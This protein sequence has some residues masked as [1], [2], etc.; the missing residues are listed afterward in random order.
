MV[1]H[2]YRRAILRDLFQKE[3]HSSV[4]FDDADAVLEI[5]KFLVPMPFLR[6]GGFLHMPF[7][8]YTQDRLEK[9]HSALAETQL[10]GNMDTHFWRENSITSSGPHC[11]LISCDNLFLIDWVSWS[12]F[13]ETK[14]LHYQATSLARNFNLRV[15]N[16]FSNSSVQDPCHCHAT[17]SSCTLMCLLLPTNEVAGR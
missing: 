17:Q 14:E 7:Y 13:N 8:I 1:L 9:S 12:L 11:S 3:Y 4:N 5:M 6:G 2:R 10:N 15:R 16:S